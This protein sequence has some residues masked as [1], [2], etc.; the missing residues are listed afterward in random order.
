M[1]SNVLRMPHCP[2]ASPLLISHS[3]L[4]M[5]DVVWK[6]GLT[7]VADELLHLAHSAIDRAD[8]PETSGHSTP[9]PW[10]SRRSGS[11]K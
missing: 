11:M 1:P 7:G 2:S 3:L 10:P 4:Q 6:A 8:E 9:Q 5:A